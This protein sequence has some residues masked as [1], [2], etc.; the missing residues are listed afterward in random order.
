MPKHI[1][2]LLLLLGAALVLALV[3]RQFLIPESFYRFGHFRA[4]SVTEIA[5]KEPVFQGS[6][7]CTACHG[8]RHAQW[9]ASSHK[10]VACETCHGPA[11]GHPAN[12]KLP[13]PTDT[14]ALCTL[15]HEAIVGR[16]QMP[17]QIVVASHAGDQPCKTCHNPHSPKIAAVA[18]KVTGDVAAGGKLADAQCASCHGAKGI[19]PN[20]TWPSLAG[21]HAPYL[22]RIMS[23]YKS[24]DQQ[25]VMMTPLAKALSDDDIRNLA[26]YYAELD[27]T[28]RSAVGGVRGDVDAGK[29]LAKNCAAC[30]GETGI[31]TNPAWPNFA[32]QKA[33]YLVNVLKAFRG[34]I[35]KDPMMASVVRGLSDA[36]INN[37]A[38]FYAAQSCK[39]PKR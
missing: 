24:G 20:E 1:T 13:T 36:D 15:C 3:A 18:A 29:V 38:V 10:S 4:N 2:R 31:G 28:D 6:G 23:A 37:L 27:C 33:G 32:G 39:Q 34:G 25:D 19:S 26:A 35:R 5:A 12:G 7:Y 14:R 30:H 9:S 21:Q 17:R 22:V 8:E 11:K 16:A